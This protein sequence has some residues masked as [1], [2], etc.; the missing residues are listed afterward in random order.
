MTALTV[1]EIV[2]TAINGIAAPTIKKT[3]TS[4]PL[5]NPWMFKK[6]TFK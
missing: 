5:E 4:T 2:A 1:N 3:A 6:T